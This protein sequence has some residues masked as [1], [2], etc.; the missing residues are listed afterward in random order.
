VN[1]ANWTQRQP[2]FVLETLEQFVGLWNALEARFKE[3][4][5]NSRLPFSPW[6]V[7][8]LMKSDI[9]PV[10]ED[11]RNASKPLQLLP[12]FVKSPVTLPWAVELVQRK[13]LIGQAL[14]LWLETAMAAVADYLSSQDCPVNGVEWQL[15][16][17]KVA[18]WMGHPRHGMSKHSPWTEE[19]RKHVPLPSIT[20]AQL[21]KKQS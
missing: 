19:A 12:D 9:P 15:W 13:T 1:K 5:E 7:V 2:L 3:D 20:C 16:E 4:A 8:Y 18:I 10:W 6:H 17:P 11:E 14:Q 21:K